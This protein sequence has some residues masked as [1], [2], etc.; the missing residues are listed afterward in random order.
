MELGTTGGSPDTTWEESRPALRGRLAGAAGLLFVA[1]GVVSMGGKFFDPL[2]DAQ[3][4]EWVHRTTP[5]IA[6]EGF[7]EGLGA[8]L[9]AYLVLHLLWATRARGPLA[10]VT[11]LS[12]AALVAVDWVSAGVYF[13]LAEAGRHPGATDGIVALFRLTKMT[14]FTDGFASGIGVL[15]VS[16]LALRARS[17]PAPVAWLGVVTGVYHLVELPLQL[18]WTHTVD[19][20]TGPIGVVFF[21]LWVLATSAVLLVRPVPR[22]ATR[23][24]VPTVA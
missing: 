5:A 15:T 20:P 2:S 6:V 10:M 7:C 19:G 1:V 3:I 9:I 13:G 12:T 17:L 18:S 21:V 24:L 8:V 16:L 11:A 14:T 23:P 22:S 4:V